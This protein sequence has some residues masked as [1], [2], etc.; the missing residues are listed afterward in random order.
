ML[1]EK[2]NSIIESLN[3]TVQNLKD[4]CTGAKSQAEAM[5]ISAED[6]RKEVETWKEKFM[7]QNEI[8][9]Q[10]QQKVLS[11]QSQNTNLFDTNDKNVEKMQHLNS[12]ILE[13]ETRAQNAEKSAFL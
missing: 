5:Q 9:N 8:T 4:K 6:L 10:L 3:E 12:K 13:Q 1:N 2:H 7:K 11:V